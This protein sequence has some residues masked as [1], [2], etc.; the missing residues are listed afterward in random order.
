[1]NARRTL[2]VD[3]TH[4]GRRAS[5]IERIT[6]ELFSDEALRPLPVEGF[7]ASGTGKLAV[8]A[9]QMARVP[10]A[11]AARPC[12]VWAF[13]GFP[14]S[15]LAAL[16]RERAVVYVHDLF[17][18][19]R[20]QDLN[21]AAKLYM[22]VPFRFA[23]ERLRYFL[24]NSV[25]T[26]DN[27]APYVRSDAEIRPYRP[28]VRNVFNLSPNG[29]PR[30]GGA[31]L[32]LGAVGTG[33][34]RKNF[35]AAAAIAVELG[36][37]LD[38]AVELHVIGRAG[39]GEDHAALSAMP[40]VKLQGFLPETKAKRV[41]EGFDALIC[42][43]HDEGL[44]LPLIEAQYAGLQAIAPDRPVFRE[45]LGASGLFV[46]P[47]DAAGAAA[48]LEAR[49]GETGWRDRAAAAAEANIRRW[50]GLAAGDRSRVIAFMSE[51]LGLVPT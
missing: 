51:R 36:R 44:G 14:P 19:T 11:M 33:E 9:A 8:A 17:L 6:E 38:R 23:V 5:G 35:R 41:M 13:S 1:M 31:P 10:L 12:T 21:R 7:G 40:H 34:P 3:R 46:D 50:N 16:F 2:V 42:T 22:S 47:D 25:T 4:L 45:V 49:F 15:P 48:V 26:G 24:V 30:T 27:L 32:V 18:I 39:W 43:S 20:K 28:E 29:P 37:R